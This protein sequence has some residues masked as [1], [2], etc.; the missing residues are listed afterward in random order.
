MLSF[1]TRLDVMDGFFT[2]YCLSDRALLKDSKI[3]FLI[4]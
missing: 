4:D 2:D 3:I 1:M